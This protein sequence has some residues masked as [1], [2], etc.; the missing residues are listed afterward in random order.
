ML[1]TYLVRQGKNTLESRP[2]VGAKTLSSYD[3]YYRQEQQNGLLLFVSTAFLITKN[4]LVTLVTNM[5]L[6]KPCTTVLNPDMR[7]IT[8]CSKVQT[9]YGNT[10]HSLTEK[11]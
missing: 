5:N 9:V 7:I 3:V 6:I 2:M 11:V 10:L 8:F 4:R 1:K